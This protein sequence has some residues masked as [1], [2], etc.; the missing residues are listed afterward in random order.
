MKIL[1][2]L[3]AAAAAYADV[4]GPFLNLTG[5]MKPRQVG[6]IVTVIVMEDSRA[7]QTANTASA[8][9]SIVKGSV[10][11]K[12][13]A[14]ALP[15]EYDLDERGNTSSSGGGNTQRTAYFTAKVGATVKEV[16][17]GGNMRI[18]GVQL[19]KVNRDEQRIE[20]KGIVRPQD[21]TQ[22]NTVLSFYLAEAD[23]KYTGKGVLARRQRRGLF[24]FLL[25]W[26]F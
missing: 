1:L 17:P 5:D 23:I 11:A 9:T 8:R 18:S 20:V 13:G 21:I 7:G 6:D 15:M 2:L 25:G 26:I 10:K 16:L 12:L 19:I 3:L 14:T 4:P 22:D 24:N